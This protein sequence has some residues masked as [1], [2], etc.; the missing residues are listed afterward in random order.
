MKSINMN[1]I[2]K[3]YIFKPSGDYSWSQSHAQVP[4]CYPLDN[5]TTRI[6]FSTRDEKSSSSTSFIDVE[7]ANPSK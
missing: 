6:F 3:G 1:W 4:F 7:A 5:D 2:K